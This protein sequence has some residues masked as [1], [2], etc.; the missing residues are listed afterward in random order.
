[1]PLLLISMEQNIFHADS[2]LM[3]IRFLKVST[4]RLLNNLDAVQLNPNTLLCA[5]QNSYYID[6]VYL[7]KLICSVPPKQLGYYHVAGFNFKNDHKGEVSKSLGHSIQMYEHYL[8]KG[9]SINRLSLKRPFL[10]L[11]KIDVIYV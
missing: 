3:T 10:F 11:S 7:A 8:A 5:R 1:M 6:M 9:M 2:L 4:I